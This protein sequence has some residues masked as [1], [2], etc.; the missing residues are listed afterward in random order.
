[1]SVSATTLSEGSSAT[2]T[3]TEQDGVVHLAFGIPTGATGA[4]GDKGDKGDKGDTGEVSLADLNTALMDKADII[5]D[6]ASGSIASFSDGADGIPLKSLVVDIDPVQDLSNGDPSP[7]NIC[8]ISG[9]TGV[10]VHHAD[11]E[12]PHV[13]D[14][15]YT[16]D[17]QSEAG[18]VYGGTLDVV[19]GVLTVDR[20][21]K[22]YNG[23]ETWNASNHNDPVYYALWNQDESIGN[24]DMTQI[25]DWLVAGG[26]DY[27]RWGTYRAQTNGA[28]VVGNL[29]N[30]VSG[31]YKFANA[32]DFKAY[33]AEHPL[34]VCYKIAE[35][36]AIQLTPN[37]INS[38]YG[39]NNIWADTGD[40]TVE[41]RADTKLYISRL[42]EPDADM[43]A[44]S[45]IV[46]GQYFMV[47]NNLYKA[48]ANIANGSAIIVGTNCI[49]K[50][51]S[52]ALNEINA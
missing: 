40:T 5:T 9:W 17:W 51:L 20:V 24:Q 41:Y 33:L 35:P 23:T 30:K 34:T 10:T 2:V 4:Q 21:H 44:D 46:S 47:G 52:E 28:I 27:Q 19:S 15:T 22:T 13:V 16:I 3:K 45:N 43:I 26:N 42:T 6:T 18:T 8:P 49:R 11:G 1:M 31:N 14:D 48:T 50:S 36:I 39:V 32:S 38:L 37:Q 7:T 25:A 29:I 12:N